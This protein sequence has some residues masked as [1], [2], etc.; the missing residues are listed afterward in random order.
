VGRRLLV[1]SRQPRRRD[2]LRQPKGKAAGPFRAVGPVKKSDAGSA[3]DTTRCT[4]GAGMPLWVVEER[5]LRLAAG[6]TRCCAKSSSASRLNLLREGS[7]TGRTGS[8]VEGT[9]RPG[10]RL[11][12]TARLR[13]RPAPFVSHRGGGPESRGRPRRWV[14]QDMGHAVAAGWTYIPSVLSTR[15]HRFDH[16]IVSRNR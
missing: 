16:L 11:Q 2:F 7:A 9:A 12:L 1:H 6:E 14:T 13:V 3:V 4:A 8:A 10:R 5:G 15:T